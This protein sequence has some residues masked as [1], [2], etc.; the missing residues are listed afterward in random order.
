MSGLGTVRSRSKVWK[1]HL[2][3][4]P[5]KKKNLTDAQIDKLA[6]DHSKLK[7]SEIPKIVK[8]AHMRS[9]SRGGVLS[10][11]HIEKVMKTIG[12]A[13]VTPKSNVEP[14]PEIAPALEDPVNQNKTDTGAKKTQDPKD[15]SIVRPTDDST[16][17]GTCDWGFGGWGVRKASEQGK[18]ETSSVI[19]VESQDEKAIAS[20]D[21]GTWATFQ[22][23]QTEKDEIVPAV[24]APSNAEESNIWAF[25]DK[26]KSKKNKAKVAIAADESV[27]KPASSET[28]VAPVEEIA[29]FEQEQAS[30]PEPEPVPAPVGDDV[31]IDSTPDPVPVD[32]PA[33][34]VPDLT[35]E[36]NL[37]WG[38]FGTKSKKGKTK[39]AT[40][41]KGKHEVLVPDEADLPA[42]PSQADVTDLWANWGVTKKGK[43]GNVKRT[44]VVEELPEEATP[45]ETDH[46]APA[47]DDLL[48][49]L[50]KPIFRNSN[51]GEINPAFA[52]EDKVEESV[53]AEIDPLAGPAQPDIVDAWSSWDG[54]KKGKKVKAKKTIPATDSFLDE[55]PPP[56]DDADKAQEE[57]EEDGVDAN[58]C[59]CKRHLSTKKSKKSKAKKAVGLSWDPEVSAL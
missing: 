38:N 58:D 14:A 32:T 22:K 19:P 53:V 50:A 13:S 54:F 51:K 57:R 24:A 36:D 49:I 33:E 9:K 45:V 27:N 44:K 41:A 7:G 16:N 59:G 18:I 46:S 39:R 10:L 17:W 42:V 35:L 56:I 28:K 5:D 40:V 3:H 29:L 4:I 26:K 47:Q 43:K 11:E 8:I 37:G 15:L 2:S 12:K 30:I 52:I 23:S 20:N 31:T 48:S 1:A 55:V 25:S 34:P 6:T 21:W